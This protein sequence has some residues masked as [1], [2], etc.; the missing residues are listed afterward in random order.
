MI[1]IASL[2][3][4]VMSKHDTSALTWVVVPVTAELVPGAHVTVRC[5][6]REASPA[7][8]GRR[9]SFW[10]N[11]INLV[12]GPSEQ[13]HRYKGSVAGLKWYLNVS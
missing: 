11:G 4:G 12:S 6:S 8:T 10:V 1:L 9:G 2:G 13:N 7:Q 5:S 3:F